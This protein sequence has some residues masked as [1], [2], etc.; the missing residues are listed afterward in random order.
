MKLEESVALYKLDKLLGK[1]FPAIALQCIESGMDSDALMELA[2]EQTPTLGEATSLFER[3]LKELG[4]ELP[5]KSRAL[6]LY[7]NIYC[8]RILA[9]EIDPHRGALDIWQLI[10]VDD[11]APQEAFE[12]VTLADALNHSTVPSF[13]KE[14]EGKVIKQ[15]RH[16]VE[17]VNV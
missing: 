13:T 11:D 1:E 4:V 17:S 8:K 14:L 9:G 6:L 7:T 16:I 3:G 12:F 10:C 15:A 2:W 5:T